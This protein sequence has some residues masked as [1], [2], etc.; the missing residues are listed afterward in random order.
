[1]S[2]YFTNFPV[3]RYTFGDEETSV[4]FQKINAYIDLFD[5]VRDQITAYEIYTIQEF[6]RPD[7]V[8]QKLYG[9][10]NYGW[11][12]F[13]MNTNLRIR[14]WPLSNLDLYT[15]SERYYPHVVL[16]SDQNLAY[17]QNIIVGDTVVLFTDPTQ[18]GVVKRIDYDLGQIYVERGDEGFFS[19]NS[20]FIIKEGLELL[21]SNAVPF[22]AQKKQTNAVHHYEDVNG[23]WVDYLDSAGVQ[24][25]IDSLVFKEN[26]QGVTYSTRLLQ[27]NEELR[28]IKIIK[29]NSI[30]RFVNEFNRLLIE[31]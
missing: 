23:N 12:F 30:E 5:Q 20:G 3:S 19:I 31:G 18:K 16:Q 2:N 24:T 8:S 27:T 7:I 4:L 11:T 15:M 29:K 10:S 6:D 21:V 22:S 28:R 1:M 14:G 17:T 26:L 13:L 25:S 9:T